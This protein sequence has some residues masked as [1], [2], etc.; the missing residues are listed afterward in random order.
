MHTGIA[1][2][3]S[4]NR[5]IGWFSSV[6]FFVCKEKSLHVKFNETRY[7]DTMMEIQYYPRTVF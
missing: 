7:I 2:R 1:M 3:R 4:Q 6:T 5:K